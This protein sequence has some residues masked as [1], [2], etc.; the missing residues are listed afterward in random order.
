MA[1]I[2]VKKWYGT[3]DGAKQLSEEQLEERGVKWLK[4][5][6]EFFFELEKFKFDKCGMLNFKDNGDEPLSIGSLSVS[7]MEVEVKLQEC[8]VGLVPPKFC[9]IG[10][11][12][13]TKSYLLGLLDLHP[14]G[15]PSMN[16][17]RIL[18]LLISWISE[19]VAS[20]RLGPNGG[21]FVLCRPDFGLQNVMISNDDDCHILSISTEMVLQPPLCALGMRDTYT[22]SLV[23]GTY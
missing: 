20:V 4:E 19:S 23:I 7:G 1:L 17:Q 9:E 10:P 22:S 13:D 3:A 11:F 12:L 21:Q 5:V 16:L 15:G 8:S 14:F 6:A 2:W 18:R